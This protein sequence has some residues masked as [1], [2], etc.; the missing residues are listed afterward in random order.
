MIIACGQSGLEF[1]EREVHPDHFTVTD[2]ILVSIPEDS[3]FASWI[4][5]QERFDIS[6]VRL[7]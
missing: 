7:V 6:E 3:E 5:L 1:I 4:R 2:M